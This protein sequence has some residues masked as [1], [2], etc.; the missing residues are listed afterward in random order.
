M[1]EVVRYRYPIFLWSVVVRYST[2]MFPLRLAVGVM[3]SA[4]RSAVTV[5]RSVSRFSL[6]GCVRRGVFLRVVVPGVVVPADLA[7]VAGGAEV[8]DVRVVFGLLDDLHLE[9]HQRVVLTAE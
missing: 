3:T 8:G 1:N 2:T 4:G 7:L 6:D 5:M 9:E